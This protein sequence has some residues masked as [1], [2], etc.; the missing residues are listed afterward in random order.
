MPVSMVTRVLL[1]TLQI[2]GF[3]C[4]NS[5]RVIERIKY[6]ETRIN[7]ESQFRDEEYGYI[8]DRLDEIDKRLNAS[9][10]QRVSFVNSDQK[11][12]DVSTETV[13]HLRKDFTRIRTA[14]REEKSETARI[15]REI[16]K[17]ENDLTAVKHDLEYYCTMNLNKTDEL[18]SRVEESDVERKTDMEMT[19]E[20]IYGVK[21]ALE[22]SIN[23]TSILVG[24]EF[25]GTAEEI[26]E[27]I[28]RTVKKEFKIMEDNTKQEIADTKAKVEIIEILV[29]QLSA[30]LGHLFGY[31]S[32]LG[33]LR[34]GVYKTRMGLEV[35]CDQTTDG[36]GWLVFQRRQSGEVDFYRNWTEYRNGFGDLNGDFWLGN[37]HLSILT[38]KGDHE[39]RI[40]MEDFDGN[41]AYAKYSKFKVYPEEDKYKLEVSG[42]SGNA[43]DSLGYHNG[44]AFSTFDNDKSGH[45]AKSY[46]GA[47]WYK[48]CHYSHLN[49]QYFDIP[50][51]SDAKGISWWYWKN[52]HYCLKSVEMKFR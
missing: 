26:E 44:M 46:H 52:N 3:Y 23:N 39:L 32:C 51:K 6:L 28:Q 10:E 17:I 45:C 35:Y 47:W 31:Y 11:T 49:G 13:D 7:T 38:A 8:I 16:P 34:S 30:H 9:T 12:S 2:I 36:G 33:M 15:R 27:S 25:K 48:S 14:F 41:K 50:G 4:S 20:E 21:S 22:N 29:S 18:I 42:Y 1:I 24:Q 37:E 5:R 19:I 43:G 40:D